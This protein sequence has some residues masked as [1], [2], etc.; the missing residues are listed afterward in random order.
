[1]FNCWATH[2]YFAINL[3]IHILSKEVL[4]K[5]SVLSFL[6]IL[7]IWG[8][9]KSE[10]SQSVRRKCRG[11][12]LVSQEEKFPFGCW[13]AGTLPSREMSPK[14]LNLIYNKD[15][16]FWLLHKCCSTP[17]VYNVHTIYSMLCFLVCLKRLVFKQY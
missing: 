9:I 2:S 5:G 11:V 12:K 16:L 6:P 15:W 14:E 13:R 10:A 1:M 3:F 4:L 8:E 7:A 17:H